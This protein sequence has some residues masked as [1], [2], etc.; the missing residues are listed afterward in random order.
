M[1]IAEKDKKH[2][3]P[4][5][6]SISV[7]LLAALATLLIAKSIQMG[8]N[9]QV[10]K[11]AELRG[12]LEGSIL[13]ILPIYLSIC[14]RCQMVC[15]CDC[16]FCKAQRPSSGDRATELPLKNAA[17]RGRLERPCWAIFAP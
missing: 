12:L 13:V 5:L 1:L 4:V 11:V 7:V 3:L 8:A 2:I 16:K 10:E 17:P 6:L 9:T 15:S 14:I